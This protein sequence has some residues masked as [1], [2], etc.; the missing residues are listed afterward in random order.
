MVS[1]TIMLLKYGLCVCLSDGKRYKCRNQY[2]GILISFV[3]G[4]V[5]SFASPLASDV[6][7]TFKCG[8]THTHFNVVKWSFFTLYKHRSTHAYIILCVQYTLRTHRERKSEKIMYISSVALAMWEKNLRMI[9]WFSTSLKINF[10]SQ[11]FCAW[12]I[13]SFNFSE[14]ENID[15]YLAVCSEREASIFFHSIFNFSNKVTYFCVCE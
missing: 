4:F 6:P 7:S 2:L 8:D 10:P 11:K 13:F 5:I 15:L 9:K 3:F 1:D 12:H 14:N